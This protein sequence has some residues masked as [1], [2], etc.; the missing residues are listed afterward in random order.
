MESVVPFSTFDVWGK[1]Q[2]YLWEQQ[3][4]HA[5]KINTRSNFVLVILIN[6]I[7]VQFC[8][9]KWSSCNQE[10]EWRTKYILCFV[11]YDT[12]RRP[13][14]ESTQLNSIGKGPLNG[15]YMVWLMPCKWLSLIFQNIYNIGYFMIFFVIRRYLNN[16]QYP[17]NEMKKISSWN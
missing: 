10:Y 2:S 5:I 15:P 13:N 14:W 6:E 12:V 7:P 11:F 17:L 3:Q 4:M 1:W 16:N 9:Q 8:K